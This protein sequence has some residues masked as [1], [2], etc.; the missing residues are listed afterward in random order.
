MPVQDDEPIYPNETITF[1]L[2]RVMVRGTLVDSSVG[3]TSFEAE[4]VNSGGQSEGNAV[5]MTHDTTRPGTWAVDLTAPDTAG[6]Y[7][8][9]ALLIAAA[10]RG[11]WVEP[12]TVTAFP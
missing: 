11:V 5:A 7:R 8:V 2:P 4:I 3:I 9:H 10:G 12:F 1:K 6:E